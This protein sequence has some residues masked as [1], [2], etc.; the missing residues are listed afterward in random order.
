MLTTDGS[1]LDGQLDGNYG[2]FAAGNVSRHQPSR[3]LTVGDG[4]SVTLLNTTHLD[5]LV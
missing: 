4:D 5:Y 3:T 1:N 2:S